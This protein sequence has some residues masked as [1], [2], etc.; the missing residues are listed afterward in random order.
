MRKKAE[1]C[2]APK[3]LASVVAISGKCR[4]LSTLS[5]ITALSSGHNICLADYK[6]RLPEEILQHISQNTGCSSRAIA[7]W[8]RTLRSLKD[9]EAKL[10]A[11]AGCE[12]HFLKSK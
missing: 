9:S 5:I 2:L 8:L 4:R 7:A 3:I 11:V 6:A 1:Y 10:G 12:C